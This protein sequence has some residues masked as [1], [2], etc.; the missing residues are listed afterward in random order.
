MTWTLWDNTLVTGQAGLDGDHE[1]MAR[2]FNLLRDTAEQRRDKESCS[3]VL[4]QIIE[5]ASTHFELER[6]LMVQRRYPKI[7]QHDGEHIMLLAQAIEYKAA[8]DAGTVGPEI[9]LTDFP[10]VWL[11]FHILFSDKDLARF[12]A[13]TG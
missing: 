9:A 13:E 8:F 10:D 4:A 3:L 2:L 5:H 7:E 11:S 6:Q 12:L 1:E